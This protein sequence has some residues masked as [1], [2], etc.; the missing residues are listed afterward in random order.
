MLFGLDNVILQ[1]EE[2]QDM[3]CFTAMSDSVMFKIRRVLMYFAYVRHHSSPCSSPCNSLI[4]NDS[5]DDAF[6]YHHQLTD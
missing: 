3:E 1:A 6:Y 2:S 5:G 4:I